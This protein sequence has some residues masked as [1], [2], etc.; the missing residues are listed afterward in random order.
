MAGVAYRG[1]FVSFKNVTYRVDIYDLSGSPSLATLEHIESCRISYGTENKDLTTGILGAELSLGILIKDSTLLT[2]CK[3]IIAQDSQRYLIAIYKKQPDNSFNIYWAGNIIQDQCAFTNNSTTEGVMFMIRAMDF[4]LLQSKF[5]SNASAGKSLS[6]LVIDTIRLGEYAE[7]YSAGQSFL[8]NNMRWRDTKITHSTSTNYLNT[9]Y[10]NQ[11]AWYEFDQKEQTNKI[12]A[13]KALLD[14]TTVLGSRLVQS[15][16]LFWFVQL[17]NYVG[18]TVTFYNLS[19]QNASPSTSTVTPF[20]T[21]DNSSTDLVI[22]GGASYEYY[23]PYSQAFI[24]KNIATNVLSTGTQLSSSKQTAYFGNGPLTTGVLLINNFISTG[25]GNKLCI[26]GTIKLQS[27]QVNNPSSIL[28]KLFGLS[29]YNSTTGQRT[30]FNGLNNTKLWNS[31]TGSSYNV[32]IFLPTNFNNTISFN[33]YTS[34]LPSA[35]SQ[36]DRIDFSGISVDITGFKTTSPFNTITVSSALMDSQTSTLY[37]LER[38]VFT[39]EI[40]YISSVNPPYFDAKKLE[41]SND[42]KTVDSE[43]GSG[44]GTL[45]A[46]SIAAGNQTSNWVKTSSNLNSRALYDMVT[47]NAL[48]LHGKILQKLKGTIKGT[49]EAN[50]LLSYDGLKWVLVSAEQDL[51][52]DEWNGEWLELTFASSTIDSA[53]NNN[54]TTTNLPA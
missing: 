15:N 5:F 30:N 11:V 34:E 14:T 43:F 17:E 45:Y 50:Q 31:T 18:S 35:V 44:F 23:R 32:Q 13:V 16:G 41:I 25:N 26:S 42:L 53:I 2:F 27:G 40:Y 20:A 12:P 1:S 49:Y 47:T 6:K 7:L 8:T 36:D 10:V 29:L 19:P 54:G 4:G 46:N 52:L 33:I 22:L 37:F 21:V 3:N 51:A 24:Q 39:N 9:L 38:G 48:I 28:I